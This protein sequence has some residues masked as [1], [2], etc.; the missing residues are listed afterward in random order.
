MTNTKAAPATDAEVSRVSEMIHGTFPILWVKA[1]TADELL[2]RIE[3]DKH[4]LEKAHDYIKV[5]EH[6]NDSRVCRFDRKVEFRTPEGDMIDWAHVGPISDERLKLIYHIIMDPSAPDV[7]G[8][9]DFDMRQMA[10]R[11]HAEVAK[12]KQLRLAVGGLIAAMEMQEYRD[13]GTFHINQSVARGIWDRAKSAA[14]EALKD[15]G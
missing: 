7:F 15:I 13:A 5:L 6:L 10:E 3:G 2:A 9:V 4:E 1:E 12:N 8:G 14:M 11:I